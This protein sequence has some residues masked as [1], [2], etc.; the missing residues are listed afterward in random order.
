M[1]EMLQE[2]EHILV[3]RKPAGIPVQSAR[4]G[5]QDMV[6]I[7]KNYRN[8]KKEAPEIY[9][10]HRLDQP[11]EGL[12]VFAKNQKAAAAL[13]GQFR[14][15]C[16][17]KRY[18]AVVEGM[19]EPAQGRLENYLLRDGRNNISQVVP[20]GTKG[21][22]RAALRYQV[23]EARPEVSLVEIL[24]E[25]GRHH[26]IRVQMANSGHPLSGDKKYNPGCKKGYLPIGLCSVGLA[27]WHPVSGKKL[28]FSLLPEGEAFSGW[29]I[30]QTW[31]AE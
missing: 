6:S 5:Q 4:L 25:T 3:C 23:L 18:L 17:D 1:L 2:D 16:V 24:L 26:Q 31:M 15:K 21:A 7:L 8:D 30:R 27:F 28:E 22:K 20:K 13:S 9:L 14:D 10:V 12:M 29:Q 11:V 19:L